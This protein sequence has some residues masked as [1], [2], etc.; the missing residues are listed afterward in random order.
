MSQNFIQQFQ[1]LTS[2]LNESNEWKPT[3][4]YILQIAKLTGADRWDADEFSKGVILYGAGEMGYQAFE[5]YS[6]QQIKVL[7]FLDD[8]PE[9]KGTNYCG[10]PILL[11]DEAMKIDCPIIIAMKHW[12]EPAARLSGADRP[13]LTS[14]QHVYL[15]GLNKLE[16]AFGLMSDDDS[17][18]VYL[19]I[20]KANIT[21]DYTLY[22]PIFEYNQYG[23]IPE[24]SR[25]PDGGNVFVDAGGFV[26]DTAEEF[27]WRAC[28][29]LQKI[30]IFE[31]NPKNIKAIKIRAKRLTEEWALKEDAIVC[32]QAGLGDQETNLPFFERGCSDSGTF[33]HTA[34]QA[35]DS[36]QIRRL[37]DYLA[38]SP[39]TLIKADIEGFEIQ[40]IQGGRE[41]IMK[42]RPKITICVYHHLSDLY[43]IPL[44]LK[45]L[46]DGYTMSLR[47]H[48]LTHNETVLYCW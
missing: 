28:G 44:L 17:K 38:G 30:H 33:H 42:Y 22:R 3:H 48:S 45:S 29:I 5:Y 24:F 41:S 40:L 37:D 19:T 11:F 36:I 8:T 27:V 15:T 7:G 32:V 35:T 25:M 1:A 46:V 20:I 6:K 34:G 4:D 47:H 39:V 18:K 13:F 23:A 21:T 16:N 14:A 10:V 26:G 9:K 12:R 31:P 2:N 43:E